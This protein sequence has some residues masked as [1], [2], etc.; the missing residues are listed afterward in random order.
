MSVAVLL[1]A[2]G[3][4][5]LALAVR[6]LLRSAPALAAYMRSAGE[7]LRRAGR[8]GRVPT[9]AER[10]RLGVLAGA[11]L[12]AVAV[13]LIGPGPL[14]ALA[15]AGPALA[16]WLLARRR[17]RYRL[18]LERSVPLM[19]AALADSV[20][21]GGSLRRALIEVGA[22]LDGPAAVE[23]ARVRADLELGVPVR[24]ALAAMADRGGSE[25]LGALAA[26]ALSQER[27]GGDLALLLRR[28]SEAAEEAA[29]A[30][31][32]ARAQ[33]AQARL[34]GGMVVA[35]PVGVALLVEMASPGFIAS[36]LGEPASA[37]M[38][39]LA[40]ALQLAGYAL[41]RRL[42]RVSE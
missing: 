9:E 4:G 13:L 34:T 33:T 38:L 23:L 14:A 10:R 1:A 41:I 31:A 25:R 11:G 29:R 27:S 40:L 30:E 32:E 5:A 22:S 19:A 26:A 24:G 12:G 16:G 7:A 37:V 39:A 18:A 8:E 21:A 2:A 17:A 36:M 42:G 15:A 20:S 35:M 3:G 6:E 28:H